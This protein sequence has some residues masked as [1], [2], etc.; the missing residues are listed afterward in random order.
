MLNTTCSRKCAI[1]WIQPAARSAVYWIQPVAGSIVLQLRTYILQDRLP[2]K[3]AMRG[4]VRPMCAPYTSTSSHAKSPSRQE[5]PTQRPDPRQ[6]DTQG[7][8]LLSAS[9]TDRKESSSQEWRKLSL[10]YYPLLPARHAQLSQ[11]AGSRGQWSRLKKSCE[12][13]Q[14]HTQPTA[15]CL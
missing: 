11:W 5:P 12:M 9:C 15:L 8:K 1:C 10:A 3:Y 14:H 6:P 7:N 13:V 4:C 2:H